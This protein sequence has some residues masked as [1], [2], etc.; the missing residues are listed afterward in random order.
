[1]ARV[2]IVTDV[3]LF[4]EGL[5]EVLRRRSGI[6]VVGNAC[7]LS[8]SLQQVSEL[9]PDV[10]LVDVRMAESLPS[11][12][13]LTRVFPGTKVIVL[14]V[15]D[16]EDDVL[17]CAEAG[18]AGFVSVHCSVDE[19][20]LS[21]EGATR[22][23]LAC[24]ARIAS[25]LL[26]HVGTLAL[27]QTSPRRPALTAR[28]LEILR[29]LDR[30]LTNKEIAR[31]LGIEVATVKNHVHRLLEKLNVHRRMDAVATAKGAVAM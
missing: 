10:A 1:M 5:E 23:E 8:E 27:A 4:G 25:V 13:A 3:R 29:L 6:T 22:G 7:N 12:R 31:Q 17:A 26:R 30:H 9:E 18:V 16:V 14:G 19:L 20:V 2:L 24:S 21:I 28:E 15:A 11:V